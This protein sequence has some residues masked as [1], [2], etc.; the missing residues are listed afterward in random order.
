MQ[1]LLSE[2]PQFFITA[3]QECPYL[4][5]RKERKLFTTLDSLN[6]I[7]LNNTLSKQGFR[8]SQDVLYRPACTDCNA[9]LS[10]RIV[11]N[12]FKVSK[13]QKRLQ[14]KNVTINRIIVR[15]FAKKDHY[16]LFQ[17]YV[18]AR[19]KA[20][21]MSDMSFSEFSSMVEDTKVS[22][23]L[24]EYRDV[25]SVLLGVCLTD[26]LD[27][28]VSMVYSFFDPRLKTNSLGTYMILDHINYANELNLK[29]VYLGYWI[30][31]SNKM[32]YKSSFSGLEVFISQAWKTLTKEP[33]CTNLNEL[34][35]EETISEQLSN[36]KILDY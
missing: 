35:V 16:A 25:N 28:G 21:G 34:L 3:P 4:E 12:N 13:S 26:V 24:I 11:I 22:T 33:M 10:A 20:G 18:Q 6:S 27:D 36:I 19:H 5:N 7:S 9:C 23:K 29:Y 14:K 8:R 32:Q 2:L 1:R 15:P 30:Q 17:Q 31:G